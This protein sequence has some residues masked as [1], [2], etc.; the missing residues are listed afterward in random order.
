MSATLPDPNGDDTAR[1]LWWKN[2]ADEYGD[3]IKELEAQMWAFEK[4]ARKARQVVGQYKSLMRKLELLRFCD[5][6]K[7]EYSESFGGW[8][9][10]ALVCRDKGGYWDDPL[11]AYEEMRNMSV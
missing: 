5:G 4:E 6:A 9:V 8:Y 11:D 1:M 3:R 10:W 2:R 7:I